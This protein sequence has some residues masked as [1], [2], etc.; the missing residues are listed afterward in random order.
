MHLF[1]LHQCFHIPTEVFLFLMWQEHNLHV[2]IP[3][4][5]H[6][7]V[8]NSSLY[9]H[10]HVW[11]CVYSSWCETDPVFRDSNESIL[12]GVYVGTG[13]K[14]HS[15]Q[16][17]TWPQLHK[18]ALGITYCNGGHSIHTCVYIQIDV[19]YFYITRTYRTVLLVPHVLQVSAWQ[20][21][22]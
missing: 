11:L 13:E 1:P 5:Q 15:K 12:L 14:L 4:R 7:N 10:V 3:N 9:I 22:V 21:S 6:K 2:H 20:G 18:P 17:Q 8:Y 19:C 16:L